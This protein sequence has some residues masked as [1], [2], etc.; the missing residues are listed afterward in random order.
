MSYKA[1]N[2][3]TDKVL[4]AIDRDREYFERQRSSDVHGIEQYYKGIQKG[5][6]IAEGY[7][8]NASYEKDGE[9]NEQ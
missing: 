1:K 9:N 4:A 3:D 6:D 7:F 5:L 8:K 2:V